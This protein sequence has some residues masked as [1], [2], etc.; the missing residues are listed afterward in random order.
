MT[1]LY[2]IPNGSYFKLKEKPHIPPDALEGDLNC[3][4]K[5]HRMDGMYGKCSYGAE[6]MYFAGWTEV[7]A[8]VIKAHIIVREAADVAGRDVGHFILEHFGIES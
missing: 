4:Y 2:E 6:D 1:K 5:F 7:D 3:V 8:V